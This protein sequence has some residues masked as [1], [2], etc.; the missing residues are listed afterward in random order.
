MIQHVNRALQHLHLLLGGL[1]ALV[2]E[3]HPL[4]C[5]STLMVCRGTFPCQE[6]FKAQ[7]GKTG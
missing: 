1:D 3:A 7:S 5:R 6:E 2:E 4:A